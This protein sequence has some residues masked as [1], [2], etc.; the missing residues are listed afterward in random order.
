MCSIRS[1]GSGQFK[2]DLARVLARPQVELVVYAAVLL[3][4]LLVALSTVDVTLLS[5]YQMDQESIRLVLNLISVVLS[6]EL[7]CRT[8]VFHYYSRSTGQFI[9]N[10]Q[11]AVDVGVV[12]VP[13][14][15]LAVAPAIQGLWMCGDATNSIPDGWAEPSS[16]INLELLRVVLRAISSCFGE[17][18]YL[19]Q[20]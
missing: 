18:G 15:L 7:I 11:F 6:L 13:L 8:M 12:L 2:E 3:S 4:S 14:V 5:T 1:H 16:W 10:A 17:F 19:C 9:W 20:V